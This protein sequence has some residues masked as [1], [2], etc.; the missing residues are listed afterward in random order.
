[1][2]TFV[3]CIANRH[4]I[5]SRAD[6][7]M[8]SGGM[9]IGPTIS[10]ILSAFACLALYNVI[11]LTFMIFLFFKRRRGLYFYSFC[12]ST[13]GII[14]YTLGLMFKFYQVLPPGRGGNWV[15]VASIIIG[16]SMMVTGQSVVLYSRLHLVV[17][18]ARKVRWVLIMIVC[19]FCASNIP[20]AVLVIGTNSARPAGFLAPYAVYER[21]QLSL[22]FA[23][24]LVIS[25]LYVY[26]ISRMLRPM[27]TSPLASNSTGG[28]S[29]GTE[30]PVKLRSERSRST[31]R[32]L[33]YVNLLIIF[34]DA[35]LVALE[36]IGH[37]ELQ[38]IYKAA[39]YSVK[40]KMEF[41]ILNQLVAIAHEGQRRSR[42]EFSAQSE[43]LDMGS[44]GSPTGTLRMDSV[45]GPEAEGAVT[46]FGVERGAGVPATLDERRVS[47]M[48]EKRISGL[49]SVPARPTMERPGV[50]RSV[51]FSGTGISN[52]EFG[53]EEIDLSDEG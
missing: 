41:R 17:H 12:V 6:Y 14:P 36:Y 4:L 44:V 50:R 28:S 2:A 37:Y 22:Y 27:L 43:A 26:E 35:T 3:N 21:L 42:A 38:V 47:G 16:W 30:A 11:E 51:T 48:S 49:S 7:H 46:G 19:N 53:L 20:T 23:Q 32:H 10:M 24:E 15:L 45:A 39:V 9:D 40:L 13:L 25:A 29:G 18:N 33:L 1:M 34:L 5:I 52:R 8:N 31:M